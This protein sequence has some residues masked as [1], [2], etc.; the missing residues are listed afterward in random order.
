MEK[1]PAAQFKSQCLAVMDQ[2]AE[3]GRIETTLS[4]ESFVRQCASRMTVLP[5]TPEIAA[6]AVSLPDRYP[7]DFRDCLIGATVLIEG[8]QL[9]T[10]D[11][12]IKKSGMVQVVG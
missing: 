8:I 3:N 12:L 10:L 9:V 6:R 4:V 2:V 5:I 1:I 7:K 11:K